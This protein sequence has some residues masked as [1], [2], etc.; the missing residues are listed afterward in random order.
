MGRSHQ[1]PDIECFW[2]E[3]APFV[4]TFLV[5]SMNYKRRE[6]EGCPLQQPFIHQRHVLISTRPKRADEG[7]GPNGEMYTVSRDATLAELSD[8]CWPTECLCGR[9]FDEIDDR[10]EITVAQLY[11]RPDSP[12]LPARR[13]EEW[14]VGRVSD[15]WWAGGQ[16]KG[17]HGMSVAIETP[18]GTWFPGD[19]RHVWQE[20]GDP[21]DIKTYSCSPSILMNW[22]T[23]GKRF[24]GFLTNGILWRTAD[25]EV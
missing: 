11:H 14:G 13:A 17:P 15:A 25:S 9:H 21:R 18:G 8:A 6:T 22:T 19:Q 5:R 12:D 24:H 4:G 23:P 10:Y 16:M 3:P 20:T 2:I 1:L 7:A